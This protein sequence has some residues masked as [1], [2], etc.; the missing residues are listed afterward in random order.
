MFNKTLISLG[1]KSHSSRIFQSRFK[2]NKLLT[3]ATL[4]GRC[5]VKS[6]G[7]AI[8]CVRVKALLLADLVIGISA[9]N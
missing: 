3:T 5:V 2:A 8:S 4:K 6:N 1:S 9:G 7:S